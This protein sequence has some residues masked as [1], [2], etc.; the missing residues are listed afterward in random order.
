MKFQR[1]L[2]IV[3]VF[4]ALVSGS[5][6]TAPAANATP[7]GCGDLENGQLCLTG[8]K[9]GESGNYLFT[10]KYLRTKNGEVTVKLGSQRKNTQLIA[11]PMWFGEMRTKDGYAELKMGNVDVASDSLHHS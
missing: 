11:V 3:A 8:G 1:L 6:V 7:S 10:A 9:I 4:S 5:L 2:S